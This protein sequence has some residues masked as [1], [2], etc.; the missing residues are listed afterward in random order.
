MQEVLASA[1]TTALEKA[2]SIRLS[3]VNNKRHCASFENINN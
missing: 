1:D 2:S 3:L